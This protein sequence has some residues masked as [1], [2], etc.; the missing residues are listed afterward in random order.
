MCIRDRDIR[1]DL[2]VKDITITSS[3][4]KQLYDH[5]LRMTEDRLPKDALK[6]SAIKDVG[7]PRLIY[8]YVHRFG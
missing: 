7:R 5:S 3:R 4:R 8:A 6:A 1:A 2:Q